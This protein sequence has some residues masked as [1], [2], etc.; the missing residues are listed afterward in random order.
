MYE[1]AFLCTDNEQAVLYN[2][3]DYAYTANEYTKLYT[4]ES[5]Q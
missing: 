2:D 5:I 1:D 3:A 4:D